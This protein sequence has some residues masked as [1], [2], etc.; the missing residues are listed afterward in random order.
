MRSLHPHLRSPSALAFATFLRHVAPLCSAA[1][2][3]TVPFPKPPSQQ[4]VPAPHP[5]VLPPDV[6][7]KD[8]E[9]KNTKGSGPGGQ[10]R[11]K[12]Q[13]AVVIKHLPTKVAGQASESRSQK[14]NMDNAVIRLRVKLAVSCRTQPTEPP[15]QPP[16]EDRAQSVYKPS[17][18]WAGRV[19]G[20]KLAINERHVDF[21][22]VLCE[23]L[24]CIWRE[25]D[26]KAASEGLGISTSQMVKLL[27]KEPTALQLVNGL[28]ASG[29]LP[30]L[31]G[32]K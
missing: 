26:V 32:A 6:L 11:N 28:R 7:L 19:K 3:G 8:C 30:P 2:K 13:T 27:A 15:Q 4:V 9:I 12:V 14:S 17:S 5:C 1:A 16:A 29:G 20:G 31:R 24:D 22:A 18:L 10:H 25:Q 21:P 23:A